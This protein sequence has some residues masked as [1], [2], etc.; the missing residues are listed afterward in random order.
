MFLGRI[1]PLTLGTALALRTRRVLY[2]YPKE[3]PA[4]G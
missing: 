4:I 1:G 3:R 2:E